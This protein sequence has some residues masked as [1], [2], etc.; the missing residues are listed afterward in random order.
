MPIIRESKV[1][2]DPKKATLKSGDYLVA[3][4][5]D[6]FITE[7]QYIRIDDLTTDEIAYYDNLAANPTTDTY[8]EAKNLAYRLAK[9]S[10]TAESAVNTYVTS[11]Q[12]DNMFVP[13]NE[14][15][16]AVVQTPATP[17]EGGTE[18]P[19]ANPGA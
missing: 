13:C 19:D 11:E 5:G 10:G 14:S 12:I 16:T 18:E 7:A 15:K 8:N 6:Q 17:G 2:L 1:A 3:T 4:N 9:I